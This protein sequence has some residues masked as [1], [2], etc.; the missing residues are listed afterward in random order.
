MNQVIWFLYNI[1]TDTDTAGTVKQDL[2]PFGLGGKE[3]ALKF[4]MYIY[5]FSFAFFLSHYINK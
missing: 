4:S 5:L 3:S 1:Y 2:F